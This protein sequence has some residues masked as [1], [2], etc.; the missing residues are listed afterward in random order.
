[1][2][3]EELVKRVRELY[4]HRWVALYGLTVDHLDPSSTCSAPTLSLLVDHL[5]GSELQ[6]VVVI[7]APIPIPQENRGGQHHP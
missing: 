3:S 4:P 2:T 5:Y 6:R 7:V 1:M